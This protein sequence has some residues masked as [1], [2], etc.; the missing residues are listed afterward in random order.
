M[1]NWNVK[2]NVNENA[3]DLGRRSEMGGDQKRWADRGSM[4]SLLSWPPSPG[5]SLLCAEDSSSTQP[6]LG[7]CPFGIET[8]PVL[9]M[10]W[11]LLTQS[12][13]EERGEKTAYVEQ[14]CSTNKVKSWHFT[15]SM[16]YP[17]KKT[18][19]QKHSFINI[20]NMLHSHFFKDIINN[21]ICAKCVTDGEVKI[22]V[23]QTIVLYDICLWS[24]YSQDS[25]PIEIYIFDL[26]L[27]LQIC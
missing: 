2:V 4:L 17:T 7:V 20:C 6:H 19:I 25:Y 11:H 21:I 13:G 14:P 3:I 18:V 8:Y 12:R 26:L 27:M 23:L 15:Y 16:L 10:E 24:Y 9:K 22:W 1:A 5:D